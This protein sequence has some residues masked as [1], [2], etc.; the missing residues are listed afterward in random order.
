MKLIPLIHLRNQNGAYSLEKK[1][2]NPD[3]VSLVEPLSK[4]KAV[5][6]FLTADENKNFF[7]MLSEFKDAYSVAK[8]RAELTAI[9][10]NGFCYY[11]LGHWQIIIDYIEGKNQQIPS[12]DPEIKRLDKDKLLSTLAHL[13]HLS[14][15]LNKR[16]FSELI[17]RILDG[18]YDV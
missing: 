4:T 1:Y 12:Q 16:A 3:N 10:T 15:N 9:H 13:E 17:K 5:N 2:F 7:P 14:V 8:S 11:I 6:I 18:E